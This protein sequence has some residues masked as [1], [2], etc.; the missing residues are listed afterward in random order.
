MNSH[1]Y[2]AKYKAEIAKYGKK[3]AVIALVFYVYACVVLIIFGIILSMPNFPVG[4]TIQHTIS[5]V[6]IVVPCLILAKR[7]RHGIASIGLH[8]RNFWPALRLGLVFSGVALLF[9]N[10]LPGLVGGWDVQSMNQIMLMLYLCVT[11]ALLEDT[12]FTGYIQ[13]R[14]YGLIKNDIAAVLIVAFLFAFIHIL[15][16]AAIFDISTAFSTV[17]S[18]LMLF[19]IVTHV[20]YN[21]MFRRYFSL[22]PIMMLHTSWNFGNSG[23]FILD[24]TSSAV[25]IVAIAFFVLLF[26]LVAW[27]IILRY[28]SRKIKA[29]GTKLESNYTN[30]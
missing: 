19:W 15:S 5:T 1:T 12:M 22:F 27:L 26:V 8:T 4:T 11:V 29:D 16:I 10:V 14:I 28:K 2:N 21:L 30:E 24:E 17:F 25:A 7:S 3:D 18:L 23:I 9:R 20:M 13:T 6:L